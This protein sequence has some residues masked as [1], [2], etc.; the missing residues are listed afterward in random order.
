MIDPKLDHDGKTEPNNVVPLH[1]M[2]VHLGDYAGHPLPW[3]AMEPYEGCD[4]SPM[5]C[6]VWD[7]EGTL[8]CECDGDDAGHAEAVAICV[9]V[10][11]A[12]PKVC[13][14]GKPAACFGSYEDD[15][16]SAYACDDC[17]GHGCEDGHC[18]P[19]PSG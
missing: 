8:I 2:P 7:A 17:C 11:R 4:G 9:A 14:C 16:H 12:G 5:Q 3:Y 1:P 13:E 18:E 19:V 6:S 15:L 10:N